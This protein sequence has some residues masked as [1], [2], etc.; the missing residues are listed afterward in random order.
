M[1]HLSD[2]DLWITGSNRIA[3][4]APGPGDLFVVTTMFGKPV[5]VEPV[6]QY[7]RAVRVAEGFARRLRHDR[8]LTIRVMGMSLH[9]LLAFMGITEAELAAGISPKVEGEFR[10]LAIDA[11]MGALRE[12]NEP[13]VRKDAFDLLIKLGILKQ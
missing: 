12:C 1:T 7:D 10:Q 6:D 5:L 4:M 3:T 2:H 13:T 8:P 9:E 11:C